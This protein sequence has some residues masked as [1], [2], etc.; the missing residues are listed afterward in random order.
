VNEIP[1]VVAGVDFEICEL[2]SA[3]LIG[4]GGIPGTVYVWDNGVFDGLQFN[5]DVGTINYTVTATDP[6]GC[7]NTDDIMITVHPKPLVT[8]SADKITGCTP[9]EVTFTGTSSTVIDHCSWNFGTGAGSK[10]CGEVEYTYE[11]EGVYDVTYFVMDVN[12]CF[13][14]ATITDYITVDQTPIASFEWDPTTDLYVWDTFVSF[15][16]TS[17]YADTYEWQFGGSSVIHTTEN[18]AYTFPPDGGNLV[19]DVILTVYNSLGCSDM[20]TT[21]FDIK[22]PII[23]YVPNIFTPDGD[24]YN[25]TFQPVF[26]NGVNPYEFRMTIYNRYGEIV[27]ETYNYDKGWDGTY[28]NQGLVQD[29]TFVWQ[30]EF[31]ENKTDKRH[32]HHGHVT[33]LK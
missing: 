16:N 8:F 24:E 32:K 22:D 14:E 5:P 12:G 9:H 2:E 23:F 1:P 10:V 13:N 20:A 29:G 25:E 30:I 26:N 18:T 19:Y 4:T 15:T 3:V 7:T 31:Q 27:F 33:I 21:T 17:E 28:G 6:N 11:Y